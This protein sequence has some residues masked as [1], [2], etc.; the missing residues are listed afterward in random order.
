MKNSRRI[1]VLTALFALI[2]VSLLTLAGCYSVKS[3][4]MK[5][6][7]GTYELTG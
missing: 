3:G 5:N 6:V 7:E 4:K 1:F 2:A